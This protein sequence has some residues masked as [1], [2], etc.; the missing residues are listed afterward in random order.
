M[1]SKWRWRLP[2]CRDAA[3]GGCSAA[4]AQRAHLS[5]GASTTIRPARPRRPGRR[6][7]VLFSCPRFRA[8]NLGTQAEVPSL[9]KTPRKT[10]RSTLLSCTF[11]RTLDRDINGGAVLLAQE[12]KRRSGGTIGVAAEPRTFACRMDCC[13]KGRQQSGCLLLARGL[14]NRRGIGGGASVL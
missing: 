3:A 2:K 14:A 10:G 11:G 5:A 9:W 12:R 6:A 4:A 13:W 1:R 8:P 7:E